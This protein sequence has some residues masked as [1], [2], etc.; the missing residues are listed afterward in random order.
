MNSNPGRGFYETAAAGSLL[1]AARQP[2]VIQPKAL[3]AP[4]GPC[5]AGQTWP[6][7]FAQGRVGRPVPQ[8][9]QFA[10]GDPLRGDDVHQL[11]DVAGTK[12]P[13]IITRLL[14]GRAHH[15]S[16]RDAAISMQRRIISKART[17]SRTAINAMLIQST[18][19]KL[20]IPRILLEP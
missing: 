2:G 19:E 18:L 16:I 8:F 1:V 9:R 14:A 15:I 7:R 3:P 10:G 5:A 12:S 11:P 17:I 20:K 13:G 4:I 6:T